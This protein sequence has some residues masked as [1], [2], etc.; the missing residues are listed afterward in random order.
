MNEPARMTIGEVARR[1]GVSVK[2]LRFY[3]GLGI[4]DVAGR[5]EAN[6]RL[7]TEDVISCVALIRRLQQAG[8]ALRQLQAIVR[9]RQRGEDPVALLRR[10]Y[11]DAL[12]RTERDLVALQARREALRGVV[13]AADWDLTLQHTGGCSVC[14]KTAPHSTAQGRRDSWPATPERPN[15]RAPISLAERFRTPA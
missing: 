15:K 1:T 7:F 2:A 3:D 4:L 6:Y 13:A 5:S 10:A 11:A 8:L 9:G 14:G 12:A